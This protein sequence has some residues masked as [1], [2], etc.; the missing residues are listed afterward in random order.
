M[1]ILLV[2]SLALLCN[3][4]HAQSADPW[5]YRGIHLGSVMTPEQV[6]HA[7]GIDKYVTNPKKEGI[8]DDKHADDVRHGITWAYEKVEFEIGPSCEV[9]DAKNYNC[10]DPNAAM[11]PTRPGGDNH[12]IVGVSVFVEQGVVKTIDINFDSILAEEFLDV[13]YRQLGKT[14]WKQGT[15]ETHIAIVDVSD[16]SSIQVDRLILKKETPKYGAYVTDYDLAFTHY[17]PMYQGT[18]EMKILDQEL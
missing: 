13:M 7:L 6:M 18:L 16:K 14:G 2:L 1:K 15:G 11:R 17:M 8:W 4:A 12:G 3:I 5:Q 9:T 10:H